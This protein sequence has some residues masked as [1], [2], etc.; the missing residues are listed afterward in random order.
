MMLW[1]SI[2]GQT[3]AVNYLRQ[4]IKKEKIVS[5]YLFQGPSGVGKT[6][7]ASIFSSALNCRVAPGEGCGSC[8]DCRKVEDG[9]HSD[10]HFLAPCSKS[11]QIVIDQIKEL[12]RMVYLGSYSDNWKVFIIQDAVS[13]RTPTG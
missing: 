2:K 9:S 8:P 10:V 12:Q 1:D 11:R 4:S 5:G 13:F 7:A 3:G 6:L